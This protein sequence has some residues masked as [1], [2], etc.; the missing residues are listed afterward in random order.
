MQGEVP[1]RILDGAAAVAVVL[2]SAQVDALARYLALLERWAARINLTG[3]RTIE[4]R[5]DHLV[6]ESLAA[7]PSIPPGVGSAV[8]VGSGAGVPGIPLQIAMP[9][10]TWTLVE[11]RAKRAAFLRAAVDDL[12]RTNPGRLTRVIQARANAVGE[13]FDLAASR[14]W[15]SPNDWF[16][17]G[18][19]L[20]RPGGTLVAWANA[21]EGRE[22]RL[23]DGRA[24][25]VTT[26]IVPRGT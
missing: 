5:V 9:N 19:R 22:Y 25:V 12:A 8:D 20:V 6:V 16:A 2:E 13:R 10:C 11:P 24:G 15:V 26:R 17:I 7:L 1:R 18:E 3:F 14:A 21:G 23:R 4:A